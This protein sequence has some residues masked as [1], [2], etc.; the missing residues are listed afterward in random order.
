MPP[1]YHFQPLWACGISY[2]EGFALLFKRE[3]ARVAQC[4]SCQCEVLTPVLKAYRVAGRERAQVGTV[5]DCVRCGMRCTVLYG[6]EVIALLGARA[7]V[8]GARGTGERGAGEGA[9]VPV[10]GGARDGRGGWL[11]DDMVTLP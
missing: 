4:P 9:G 3:L 7:S 10:A 2:L 8:A 5:Y 11:D 1:R 6:G